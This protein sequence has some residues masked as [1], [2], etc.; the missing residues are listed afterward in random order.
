MLEWMLVYSTLPLTFHILTNQDSVSYVRTVME[1]V[2]GSRSGEFTYNIVQLTNV[3]DQCT[4]KICP[5]LKARTD[6]C[7]ILMGKMTPLL[8]PWLFPHLDHVLFIDRKM[9]V[10]VRLFV[11]YKGSVLVTVISFTAITYTQKERVR[12]KRV[13]KKGRQTKQKVR[14]FCRHNL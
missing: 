6:F 1:K 14:C 5:E 9:L 12:E 3:I 13:N 8:F 10:Q 7:E 11:F 4:H 2:N